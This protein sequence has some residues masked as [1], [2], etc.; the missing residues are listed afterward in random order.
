MKTKKKKIEAKDVAIQA[1]LALYFTAYAIAHH[2]LG[3]YNT[4]WIFYV[5][6]AALIAYII[7]SKKQTKRKKKLKNQI[8][9]RKKPHILNMFK[10]K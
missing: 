10:K 4:R 7:Y 2:F 6:I 3:V 9:L 5:G 1:G 8:Y